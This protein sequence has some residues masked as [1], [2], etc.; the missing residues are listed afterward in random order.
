MNS[1]LYAVG[2]LS[3]FLF[4]LNLMKESLV[5]LSSTKLN[6]ILKKATDSKLKAFLIGIAIT[7]IIQ[8]SS[9]ITAMTVALISSKLLDF[10]RGILIMVGANIGT[11]VTAFMF[12]MNIGSYSLL[13]VSLGI[14]LHFLSGRTFKLAGNLFA[15]IGLLFFGLFIMNISLEQIITGD[16]FASIAMTISENRILSLICGIFISAFIQSSSATIGVIETLYSLGGIPLNS[17]VALMLGANVGT[18]IGT[19]IS[20]ISQTREAKQAV[21]VNILFNA[22]GAF[23]FL[24]FLEPIAYGFTYLETSGII[25]SKTLTIAYS[26]LFFNIISAAV[27]YGIFRWSM[28]RPANSKIIIDTNV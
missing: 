10:R 23:V 26:H 18:A 17:A 4:G 9:A 6:T 20:A 14:I 24:V 13:F 3:L 28:V 22:A 16:A 25:T 27:F 7:A 21:Y 19:L 15:A 5:F 12:T 1:F 11:T 2:G 8:S